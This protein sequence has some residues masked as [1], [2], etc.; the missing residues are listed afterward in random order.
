MFKAFINK[1]REKGLF[2]AIYYAFDLIVKIPYRKYWLGPV[3]HSFSQAQEDLLISRILGG[4]K[5]GFY[6]DIGAYDPHQLSNTKHFYL[7][8]WRGINVE[9]NKICHARFVAERPGDI[10]L[11][12]GVG[13]Q[14]GKLTFYTMHPA[15]LSTF[16]KANARESE[17]MGCQIVSQEPIEVITLAAL[18]ERHVGNKK[19]DFMTIDAEGLDVVV[20]EG[21]DWNRWRP[22]AICI[23]V[24]D[25][26]NRSA[27]PNRI[28]R[29]TEFMRRIHYQPAATV[30]L[31]GTPLNM[32]FVCEEWRR[33]AGPQ[34]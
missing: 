7:K 26:A 4:R 30:H 21:N 33:Q 12:V 28:K 18:F 25:M 3:R 10:N 13:L 6:I 2:R 9:P 24:G 27:I 23:E 29:T 5:E 19:V 31:H 15:A 22:T 32:I 11:N 14:P 8:G 17:K 20:L 16:S 34:A 1:V